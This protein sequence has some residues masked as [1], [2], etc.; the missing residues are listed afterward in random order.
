MSMR[1]TLRE[2]LSWRER[3]EREKHW[4]KREN[5]RLVERREG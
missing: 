5:G 2:F 4:S 1:K 3:D